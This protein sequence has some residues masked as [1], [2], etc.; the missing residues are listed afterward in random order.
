MDSLYENDN[1]NSNLYTIK[2]VTVKEK[3][4][5]QSDLY[6]YYQNINGKNLFGLGKKIN[7][8]LKDEKLKEK[9]FGYAGLEGI[10]INENIL[11]LLE[12]NN[13]LIERNIICLI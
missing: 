3:S 9:N 5:I 1:Q 8:M 4:D 2:E 6:K 13:I 10:Y 12:V 7:E 11:G